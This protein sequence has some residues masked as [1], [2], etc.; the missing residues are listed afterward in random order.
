VIH[1]KKRP[2][3]QEDTLEFIAGSLFGDQEAR[4][5]AMIERI[6]YAKTLKWEHQS[7]YRLA[8]LGAE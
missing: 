6:V 7:E 5:K 3:L 8:I 1:R 2:P 4:L